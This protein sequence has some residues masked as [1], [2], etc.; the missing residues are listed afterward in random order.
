MAPLKITQLG[1]TSSLA[2]GDLISFV[3]VSDTTM[4]PSGTNK[5]TNFNDFKISLNLL[6]SGDNVSKLIN[7]AGYITGGVQPSSILLT[8]I[9]QSSG[10]GFILQSGNSIFRG[11]LIAGTGVSIT[12]PSGRNPLISIGQPV[13][14]TSK[15]VF[16]GV[17]IGLENDDSFIDVNSDS[18]LNQSIEYGIRSRFWPSPSANIV[19]YIDS[20]PRLKNGNVD[21]VNGFHVGN[22]ST[23]SGVPENFYGYYCSD[24]DKGTSK[25]V[26]FYGN[27]DNA[28]GSYNLYLAG[29]APNYFASTILLG[30]DNVPISGQNAIVGTD[31]G[32]DPILSVGT[33]GLWRNGS[34][35]NLKVGSNPVVNLLALQSGNPL[36]TALVATSGNGFVVQ[37]GSS[38][39]REPFTSL[40]SSRLVKYSGGF[41][42]SLL[43]DDGTY[44]STRNPIL[45]KVAAGNFGTIASPIISTGIIGV[46]VDN[47][48]LDNPAGMFF[49]N[50]YSSSNANFIFFR[51]RVNSAAVSRESLRLNADGGIHLFNNSGAASIIPSGSAFYCMS[52]VAYTSFINQDGNTRTKRIS[53]GGIVAS[54]GSG[55]ISFNLNDGLV[56]N[57]TLTGNATISVTNVEPGDIFNIKLRQD[58]TGSRTVTWFSTINWA[59]GSAPTLTTTGNKADWIT[60]VCTSSGVYDGG[61]A[62]ANV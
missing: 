52:G 21:Q 54:S 5:Q 3:D 32:V 35:F 28:T 2:S 60:I 8:N 55:N 45:I 51:T 31:N 43:H 17:Y 46:G 29:T 23:F 10:N 61:V 20:S 40:T 27:I 47:V 18:D 13:D 56:R 26:A 6:S 36:L 15:V 30:T 4:S 38:F 53:R 42:S 24:L 58:A 34:Q 62:M 19:R 48:I 16:N 12:N 41:Q 37:S 39:Y 59:G 49:G 9:V 11:G 1:Y 57:H 25:N 44:L 14:T 7:D 50:T 33:W 22:L